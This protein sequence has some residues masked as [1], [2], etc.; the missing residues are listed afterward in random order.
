MPSLAL[1]PRGHLLYT[2]AR[3]VE[4]PAFPHGDR[5]EAAF[6]RGSGQGLLEL[7]ASEVGTTLPAD[8]SYWRDFAARL[9]MTICSSPDVDANQG[10]IPAPPFA[11]LDAIAAAAPPMT[12]AEYI[13]ASVLEALWNET[14]AAFRSELARSKVPV[15]EFLHGKNPAWHLVGRVNFNLAENRRDEEAPFAFPATYPTQ[16]SK[17]ARAQHLP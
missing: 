10:V 7:G 12:G 14:A 15:A 8:V 17:A 6:A 9:V 1:P 13:A 3:E 11:E 5:L 4:E 2:A 16:L